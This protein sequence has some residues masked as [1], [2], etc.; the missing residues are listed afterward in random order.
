MQISKINESVDGRNLI[1]Y[2]ADYGQEQ[3]LE[4][5]IS[6]SADVNVSDT[7]YEEYGITPGRDEGA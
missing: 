5:L 7:G 6:K 1:H 3:V 2:A 4:Y